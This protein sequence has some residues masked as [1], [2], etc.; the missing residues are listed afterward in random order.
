MNLK[1][2]VDNERNQIRKIVKKWEYSINNPCWGIAVWSK[3][4]QNEI[5]N[6]LKTLNLETCSSHDIKEITGRDEIQQCE[7]DHCGEYSWDTLLI[8]Q[9]PDYDSST[10]RVCLS[11]LEEA[12]KFIK[13]SKN[14]VLL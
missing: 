3:E 13:E 5:L 1:F 10:A 2:H 14:D 12:V 9:E 8:G 4:K 11:C 7:C 6:E